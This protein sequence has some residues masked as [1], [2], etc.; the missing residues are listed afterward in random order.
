MTRMSFTNAYITIHLPGFSP[1][2]LFVLVFVLI[3]H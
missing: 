1:V 3:D 2:L